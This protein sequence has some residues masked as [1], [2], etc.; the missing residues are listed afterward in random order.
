METDAK[1]I[2]H[3]WKRYHPCVG[4]TMLDISVCPQNVCGS[5][6]SYMLAFSYIHVTIMLLYLN[7]IVSGMHASLCSLFAACKIWFYSHLQCP[8]RCK[9]LF[10]C[11]EARFVH[12]CIE[13]HGNKKNL[14]WHFLSDSLKTPPM[15]VLAGVWPGSGDGIEHALKWGIRASAWSCYVREEEE[16]EEPAGPGGDPAGT[17]I[18]STVAKGLVASGIIHQCGR[19]R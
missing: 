8:D 16:K 6:L 3:L 2:G 12:S 15:P 1:Q 11:R 13:K 7:I 14:S 5:V 19:F 18:L 9:L 4:G 10:R 17:L